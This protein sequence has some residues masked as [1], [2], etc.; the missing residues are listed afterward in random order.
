[1]QLSASFRNAEV[2]NLSLPTY[3]MHDANAND[4]NARLSKQARISNSATRSSIDVPFVAVER[5]VCEVS[6][7][8][9]KP[10]IQ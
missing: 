4:A 2:Q 8:V 1:M 9:F 6:K 5:H 7:T 10:E 3:A